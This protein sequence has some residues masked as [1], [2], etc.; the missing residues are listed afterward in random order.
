MFPLRLIKGC[1]ILKTAAINHPGISAAILF[2]TF[3]KNQ[4]YIR[5]V[6]NPLFKPISY[7]HDKIMD[8]GMK[9][10]LIMRFG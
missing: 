5:A 8:F 7:V 3:I 1:F 10:K 4:R 9:D 6:A 2:S